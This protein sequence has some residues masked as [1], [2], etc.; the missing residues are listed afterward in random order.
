MRAFQERRPKGRPNVESNLSRFHRWAKRLAGIR[1]AK[2]T[3]EIT[4][5]TDRIL[6]IR[7]RRP[8]RAWC[9]ECGCL[10]DMLTME[11]VASVMSSGSPL[12]LDVQRSCHLSEAEDGTG[13]V[14]LDSFLKSL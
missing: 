5:Q 4:V 13:L 3:T 10:T 2:K 14:C 7:R 12:S 9:H 11:E 8:I 6:V 1:G